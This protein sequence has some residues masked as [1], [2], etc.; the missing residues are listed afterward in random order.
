MLIDQRE[1]EKLRFSSAVTTETVL[2][3]VGDYSLRGG[4][5]TVAIERKR[6]GELAQCCGIDRER[7]IAQIE[8]L[9]DYP[10]RYVVVEATAAEMVSG[11]YRSNINPLSVVGTVIKICS[12]WQIP[13]LFCGDARDTALWVERI[14]IREHKRLEAQRKA[15]EREVG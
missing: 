15:A 8:R 10:V 1:R 11:I 2:L 5:S 13:V 9:R 6:G 7:F 12:D 3:P 4:S 14:L